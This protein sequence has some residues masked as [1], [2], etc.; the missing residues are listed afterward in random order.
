MQPGG[1]CRKPQLC[2][3]VGSGKLHCSELVSCHTPHHHQ[4]SGSTVGHIAPIVRAAVPPCIPCRSQS[5]DLE[6]MRRFGFYFGSLAHLSLGKPFSKSFRK[7]IH[8]CG[9]GVPLHDI[10]TILVSLNSYSEGDPDPGLW[11]YNS[12]HPPVRLS[13]LQLNIF[14]NSAVCFSHQ[15]HHHNP[16]RPHGS[17]TV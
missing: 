4:C 10:P 2:L 11:K 15:C 8:F 13:A 3:M 1:S 7:F 14:A 6:I 9:H 5:F 17:E 12:P 16:P